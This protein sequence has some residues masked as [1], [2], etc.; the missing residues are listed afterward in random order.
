MENYV[1][2]IP[3]FINKYLPYTEEE[4]VQLKSIMDSITN[5]IPNDKMG[6]VWNNHNRILKTNEPT[7]CSCKSAANHWVR[8]AGT[9]RNFILQVESQP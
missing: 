6:W 9:I 4:Y 5:Y 3:Y 1:T 7:P 2:T 8:A